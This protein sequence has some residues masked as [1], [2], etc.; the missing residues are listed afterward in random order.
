MQ[1]D[2]QIEFMKINGKLELNYNVDGV[3][4][5]LNTK[6]TETNIYDMNN[7]LNMFVDYFFQK[8]DVI[9]EIEKK[10]AKEKKWKDLSEKICDTTLEVL[11]SF[12]QP[13]K[14]KEQPIPETTPLTESIGS[15]DAGTLSDAEYPAP[16]VAKEESTY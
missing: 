10:E 15:F 14:D 5:N 11:K 6:I 12:K 4:F 13:T 3:E 1:T 9:Q 2:E 7:I 8:E 16:N